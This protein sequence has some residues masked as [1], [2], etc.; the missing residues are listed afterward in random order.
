MQ[1][2]RAES[3]PQ[4]GSVVAGKYVVERVLGVGGMGVV[5][6]ARHL[7]LDERVALKFLLPETLQ[8]PDVVARFSRE[9]RAA[10]R[11][12]SEHVARIIDVGRLDDGAPYIVMEYLEGGDL[13]DLLEKRGAISV[14]R[15]VDFTLQA[16][17]AVAAA[18]ALGIVHRDLKPANLFMTRL[19]D[20]SV[21]IKVLDFGIS[22]RLSGESVALTQR[23]SMLGSPLYMP[24]EQM[25][26]SVEVDTRSD[27]WSI[28]VILYELLS[29][30]SPF[31]GPSIGEVLV[32]VLEGEPARLSTLVPRLPPGLEQVIHKCLAKTKD[33][34][35]ASVGD[36]AIALRP[37]AP[38][39]SWAS[40][41]RVIGSLRSPTLVSAESTQLPSSSD[42]I[43]AAGTRG[44]WSGTHSGTLRTRWHLYAL[45]GA[46]VLL[47]GGAAAWWK[48]SETGGVRPAASVAAQVDTQA[49]HAAA[50]AAEPVRPAEP[51]VAPV[52]ATPPKLLT[53]P[54]DA[55]PV[56]P[57][58]GA[59]S[60]A[61]R[62][63]PAAPAEAPA[64][65]SS[66]APA[67]KPPVKKPHDVF[68][69][70]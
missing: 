41:D 6:A 31:V 52:T 30:K 65:V 10:V 59:S 45:A 4:E 51:Q 54:A 22:K 58:H 42:P 67:A 44:A 27:I 25:R 66:E 12:K 9:A 7:E 69:D 57:R 49:T 39:K 29:G 16:L 43:P 33:N 63:S 28:G 35:Y 17:E 56:R 34:R 26:D 5:V 20:G 60:S 68:E 53:A 19:G 62:S 40:I 13:A 21:S 8:H 3:G 18:H 14:E 47:G 55:G 2:Q 70:R 50:S 11:I 38:P 1:S 37:F 46:L 36:L 24:P 23:E 32:N 61:R 15:A 48:I 64:A